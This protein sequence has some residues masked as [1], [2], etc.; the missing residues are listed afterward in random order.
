MEEADVVGL[1]ESI[2]DQ[3]MTRVAWRFL[4]PEL[5][6][7]A[8]ELVRERFSELDRAGALPIRFCDGAVLT[9]Y[10]VAIDHERSSLG[11]TPRT[12]FFPSPRYPLIGAIGDQPIALG[13][14]GKYDL[15]V[16]RDEARPPNLIARYGE[17]ADD[18]LSASPQILGLTIVRQI[19]E[20]FPEALRRLALL[21]L[22][23]DDGG[24][25]SIDPDGLCTIPR[26]AAR[27]RTPDAPARRRRLFP[28]WPR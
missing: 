10:D 24:R 4:G 12:E 23:V 28:W 27:P 20:P 7:E 19:G 5:V 16:A 6:G 1:R 17:D 3:L 18:Y 15:W 14:S 2:L 25:D 8:N 26:A 21:G 11:L 22:L 9:G 13:F